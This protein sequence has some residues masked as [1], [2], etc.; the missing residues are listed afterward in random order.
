VAGASSTGTYNCELYFT[1]QGDPT[2][3]TLCDGC[4][5]GFDID[6]T[7][8][9]ASSTDDGTCSSIAT[10]ASYTYGYAPDYYAYGPYTLIEYSGT[11]SWYAW[12][13][14]D[15]DN[16]TRVY[17][18]G[19][20]Y[21]DYYYFGYYY[22]N[23][24]YG[25]A[26][27]ALEAS[28]EGAEYFLF[29]ASTTAGDLNCELAWDISGTEFAGTLCTDC[30]FAFDLAMTYDS[31]A[32][33]DD[34]TCI[35]L[36]TDATYTYGLDPDYYGY[37]SYIL[38]YQSSYSYWTSWSPAEFDSTTMEFTY[39]VGYID[40]QYYAQYYTYYWYGDAIVLY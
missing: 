19:I 28:F 39:Y 35:S 34:G 38:I 27:V 29:G 21:E 23:Y 22:T 25:A 10:D 16:A 18:Y 17:T 33:T 4:V 11:G 40:Y 5:F 31:S 3:S 2:T 24:W 15:W 13:P 8:E 12:A 7:Y 36:A 1:A 30:T 32:S 6:M 26:A 9:S 14:T 37:G 20:G